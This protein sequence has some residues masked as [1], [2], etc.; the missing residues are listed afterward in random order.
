VKIDKSITAGRVG[1]KIKKAIRDDGFRS[2]SD[3]TYI[4]KEELFRT[5]NQSPSQSDR[6]PIYERPSRFRYK[7]F[8]C[9]HQ[10]G[11]EAASEDIPTDET[12]GT[13]RATMKSTIN[14]DMRSWIFAESN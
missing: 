9:W 13:F 7:S 11:K 14:K 1:T 3:V 5:R 2:V 12:Y 10:M 6:A 4:L 8:V